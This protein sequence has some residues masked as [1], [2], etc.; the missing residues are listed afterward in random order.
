MNL[1]DLPIWRLGELLSQERRK[2]WQ[3]WHYAHV[4]EY[5]CYHYQTKWNKSVARTW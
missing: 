1:M 2:C 4:A 3:G 5:Y